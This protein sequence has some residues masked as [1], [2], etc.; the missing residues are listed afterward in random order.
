M[1]L[2]AEVAR[3]RVRLHGTCRK[4]GREVQSATVNLAAVFE[5]LT[6]LEEEEGEEPPPP[7]S[8]KV[9]DDDSKH[10]SDGHVHDTNSSPAR[11][12]EVSGRFKES[13]ANAEV[14]ETGGID[15]ELTRRA[16]LRVRETSVNRAKVENSQQNSLGVLVLPFAHCM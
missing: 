15:S 6:K 5:K 14:A 8:G 11:S 9:D 13:K 2:R 1:H 16:F 12:S 3:S 10:D 4:R 7:N